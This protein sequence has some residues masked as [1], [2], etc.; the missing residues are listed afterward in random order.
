MKAS[1]FYGL[2]TAALTTFASFTSA[3]DDS[4][5]WHEFHGPGRLNISPDKG[6]LK[7]WPKEG[8]PLLWKFSGCGQG[9]SGVTIAQGML[10][11]AGDF[12]EGE[13]VL[14]LS[15]D[16]KL[17]W[18]VVNGKS[19]RGS[20]P[21]SRT[22]PTYNDGILYH[23]NPHGRLAALNA[24]SG[25]EIWAVDLKAE[26]EGKPG[27]WAYAE[28]VCIEGDKVLCMPGGAKGRVVALDK[29]TG[30]TLWV[31]TDTEHTA[32]YCSPTVVSH[33]GTRQFITMT[34]KSVL[35]ID[36]ANGKLLWSAPFQPTSPQNAL[37]PVYHQGH[38]FVAGGHLKG[39]TLFKL[40]DD[41]RTAAVVW[42]RKDLDNC[43]GGEVLLEGKLFGPGCRGG[44]KN[45]HCVDFLTGKN[46]KL[47]KKL[48]KVGIT[49]ADGMLYCME[50]QGT[51]SLLS[52]GAEGFDVVSQFLVEKRP[53]CGFLAH[54]I[55]CGGRL[56]IRGGPDLW[57]YDVKAR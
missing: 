21:G 52:I 25:K 12:A 40:S 27:I 34:Q 2:A 38:I 48:G 44:G 31:N 16:G 23:M 30:K 7:K 41:S 49:C 46:V 24:K 55:V 5:S 4:P 29:R 43:H 42:S 36:V 17:L 47:D 22:T 54:P 53:A 33:G 13:K 19:W 18:E 37:T 39:G 11:T 56:Y 1:R 35:G 32:A 6:L 10:F 51:L 9:Y 28:N 8:P 57:V 45:F 15:M 3:S 14:A 26:F 50:H 20:A